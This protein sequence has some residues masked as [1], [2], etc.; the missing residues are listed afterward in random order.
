[1]SQKGSDFG[2][3]IGLDHEAAVEQETIGWKRFEKKYGIDCRQI[4]K[5]LADEY[6]KRFPE[7]KA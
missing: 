7:R 4:A 2:G 5:D 1:M 6:R 3:G